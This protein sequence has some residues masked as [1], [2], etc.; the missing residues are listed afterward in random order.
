MCLKVGAH[1]TDLSHVHSTCTNEL[2]LT[3]DTSFTLMVHSGSSI[4]TVR[5]IIFKL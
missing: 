2:R 5:S 4:L 3:A 1:K